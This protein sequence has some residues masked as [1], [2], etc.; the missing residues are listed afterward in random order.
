[1]Q[2]LPDNAWFSTNYIIHPIF[3]SR[4]ESILW[5]LSF[6]DP[7][8]VDFWMSIAQADTP[9]SRQKANRTGNIAK[10][11]SVRKKGLPSFADERK[12]E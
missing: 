12:F 4:Q 9:Y 11:M 6:I 1:M 10:S 5:N 7:E 3:F 2:S 8:R